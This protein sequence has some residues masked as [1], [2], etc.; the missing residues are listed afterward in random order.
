MYVLTIDPCTAFSKLSVSNGYEYCY[1]PYII[2]TTTGKC[3]SL[4]RGSHSLVQ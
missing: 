3:F 4:R 1:D 2:E